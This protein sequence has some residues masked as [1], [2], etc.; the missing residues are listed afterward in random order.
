[1]SMAFK[2]TGVVGTAAAGMTD[3][4][5]DASRAS[6]GAR[7]EGLTAAIL[8]GYSDRALIIHSLRLPVKLETDIDHLV[9]S[10]EGILA[11]DSKL[12][13]PGYYHGW[14]GTPMRGVRREPHVSAAATEKALEVLTSMLGADRIDPETFSLVAV[15]GAKKAESTTVSSSLSWRPTPIIG[16]AKLEDRV[17]KFLTLHPGPAEDRLARALQ[18]IHRKGRARR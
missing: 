10:G 4:G 3:Q 2:T 13:R 1:M 17:E 6:S 7:G 5:F 8:R 12:W 16:A 18:R 14:F 9:V 11:I 15:H